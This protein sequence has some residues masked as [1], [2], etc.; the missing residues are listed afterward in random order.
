MHHSWVPAQVTA[1]RI[2]NEH[3]GIEYADAAK[4][5][6]FAHERHRH[7]T[8]PTLPDEGEFAV[9]VTEYGRMV[10]RVLGEMKTL[11]H[12]VP[13]RYSRDDMLYKLGRIHEHIENSTEDRFRTMSPEQRRMHANSE[14]LVMCVGVVKY[15]HSW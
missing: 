8:P 11:T 12:G 2:D 5:W 10:T 13:F 4:E 3:Q 9:E 14:F 1:L 7:G 15:H 6:P